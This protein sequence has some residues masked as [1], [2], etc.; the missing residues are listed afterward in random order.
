M[1]VKY[2]WSSSIDKNPTSEY[3]GFRML[4][5]RDPL[6]CCTAGQFQ[7]INILRTSG[8]RCVKQISFG[9][10][11][12]RPKVFKPPSLSMSPLSSSYSSITIMRPG[13]NRLR[14]KRHLRRKRRSKVLRM[15][16][17]KSRFPKKLLKLR[18]H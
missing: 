7:S 12:Y 3:N 8:R 16:S 5:L 1:I 13:M 11:C 17:T 15:E 14:R 6:S 18:Q 4:C 10:N 2:E 9:R